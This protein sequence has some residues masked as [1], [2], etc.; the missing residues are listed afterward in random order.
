MLNNVK[1]KLSCDGD[2]DSQHSF[3]K[4]QK[5]ANIYLLTTNVFVK[6]PLCP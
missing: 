2:P 1:T 4:N 5:V 3:E 6:M